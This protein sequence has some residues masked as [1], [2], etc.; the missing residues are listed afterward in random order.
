MVEVQERIWRDPTHSYLRCFAQRIGVSARGKSRRLQRVLSDF[1]CEHSF[2]RSC[3]RVEEHYGFKLNAPAVR[4][5]TLAQS[6]RAVT[7]LEK[8]YAKSFRSLPARGASTLVAQADGTMICTVEAGRRRKAPRP[9]EWKEMRLVAAQ[10]QGTTQVTYAATMGSV[11]EVGRRWGHC[12]RDAGWALESRI[13]VVGDGAEWITLQRREVFGDQ[14]TQLTDFFH[15]SEYLGAAAEVCRAQAPRAWLRTQQKRLKRGAVQQVLEALEPCL[16]A[17]TVDD[18]DAPVRAAHRYL[19]NRLDAL[20]YPAAIAADLPIGSGLIESG[21]K[22][23]LHARLKGPG[24]AWLP[25]NADAIAQLRV[26]RANDLW[27]DFWSNSTPP[28]RHLN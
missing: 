8:H 21:H 20:D 9:R 22:H 28:N 5:V 3:A 14:A 1:G 7:K 11:A 12:A 10:A 17:A 26:L 15:V 13:H 16:E 2:A 27:D 4:T 18:A 23:V 19:S 6:R 25:A 24:T